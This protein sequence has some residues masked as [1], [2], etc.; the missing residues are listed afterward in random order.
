MAMLR[1]LTVA[2]AVVLLTAV[3]VLARGGGGGH[4][5]GAAGAASNGAPPSSLG[6]GRDTATFAPGSDHRS[7]T[8]QVRK[9]LDNPVGDA[10][11]VEGNG[12]IPGIAR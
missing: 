7:D 2:A 4:G 12:P 5:G 11:G 6:G 1:A 8:G 10:L 9:L 3:P